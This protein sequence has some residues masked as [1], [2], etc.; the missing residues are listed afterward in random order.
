M[1]ATPADPDPVATT[2]RPGGDQFPADAPADQPIPDGQRHPFPVGEFLARTGVPL[3][4]GLT[5]ATT[6][7]PWLLL[8]VAGYSALLDPTSPLARALSRALDP[9]ADAFG[10][11]LSRRIQR[12]GRKRR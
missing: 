5:A 3:T 1:T 2:N 11:A 12:W 10:Q 7:S 6:R 9:A 4:G 8:V